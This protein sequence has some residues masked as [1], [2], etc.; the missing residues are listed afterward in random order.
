MAISLCFQPHTGQN[1]R[2]KKYSGDRNLQDHFHF[3]LQYTT[4]TPLYCMAGHELLWVR[5]WQKVANKPMVV[6][7]GRRQCS[8]SDRSFHE[9][10]TRN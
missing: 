1:T 8:L 5:K 2:E 9:L 3:V 6:I 10:R 4:G 7:V